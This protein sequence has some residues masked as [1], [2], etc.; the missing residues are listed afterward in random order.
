VNDSL[1]V[2]HGLPVF[3]D[4]KGGWFVTGE[5]RGSRTETLLVGAIT[6]GLLALFVLLVW[7]SN[8]RELQS[9]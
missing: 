5:D 9:R 6:V 4:I 3:I 1:P 7:V 2:F 8:T